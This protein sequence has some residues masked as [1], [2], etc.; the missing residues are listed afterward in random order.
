M[1]VFCYITEKTKLFSNLLTSRNRL[2]KFN[3]AR[4]A[5]NITTPYFVLVILFLFLET[6]KGKGTP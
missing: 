3:L 1:D 5:S 6:V 4:G 2:Y